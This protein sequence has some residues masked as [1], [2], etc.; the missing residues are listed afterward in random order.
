MSS[1]I[2]PFKILIAD[3]EPDII[4]F[5]QYNLTKQGYEVLTANDGEAAFLLSQN[6]I[7]DLI[8]LDVMMPLM[9][10]IQVCNAIRAGSQNATTL[11][12]FLTARSEDLAQI[13]GFE[14]GADD[15][16]PKPIRPQLLVSRIQALL[17][18]VNTDKND[19]N[20]VLIF[21]NLTIN[22]A[23]I[24]VI[25]ENKPVTLAR[26]EFE[27]FWLLASKPSKVFGR[28]EIFAKIWGSDVIVGDRTIDVHIRKIR[29][30]LDDN[31]IKTIKGVGYKFE[32]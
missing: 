27:I 8:I 12:A 1:N 21:E 31:F 11:I 24:S 28:E 9:N 4:E 13:E 16:I 23:N 18:R 6:H 19:Q 7:F 3:D 30:K 15:Y 14:A 2:T 32:I 26:K 25:W 17:R 10:G 20:E 5:V 29:E 22:R